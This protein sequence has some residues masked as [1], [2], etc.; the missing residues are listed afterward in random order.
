MN[1]N[2]TLA[3]FALAM[4]LTALSLGQTTPSGATK[5]AVQKLVADMKGAVAG[6]T[7]SQAMLLDLKTDVQ[8]ATSAAVKPDPAVVKA[9][10]DVVKNAAA[11]KKITKA[12]QAAILAAFSKVMASA[13][14]P[15]SSVSEIKNDILVIWN[16]ADITA[17]ELTLIS[18]DIKALLATLPAKPVK[19]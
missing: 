14:I 6:S 18:E 2:K 13:N 3:V 15:M 17:E 4:S 9:F 16:A 12:E 19:P 11:D 5:A 1:R 8:V 7:V 10:Q